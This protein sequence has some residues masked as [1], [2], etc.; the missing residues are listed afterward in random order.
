MEK[1][2]RNLEETLMNRNK[3]VST[4]YACHATRGGT[5]TDADL[6]YTVEKKELQVALKELKKGKAT[7]TDKIPAEIIKVLNGPAFKS[8]QNILSKILQGGEVPIEWLHIRIR[9][10]YK[11]KGKN[12][13]DLGNYRPIAITSTVYKLMAIIMKK[14]LVDWLETHEKLGELQNGFRPGRRGTDNIFILSQLIESR[15]LEGKNMLACFLD[16][17]KA[18][19]SVNRNILWNKMSALGIPLGL[20]G[21]LQNMYNSEQGGYI[22]ELGRLKTGTVPSNIGLKQGCPLSPI[23]FIIY[24]KE[25]EDNLIENNVGIELKY[26]GS[27]A[28]LGRDMQLILT[29]LPESTK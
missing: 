5:G 27:V 2:A 26:E 18:Y 8:L 1:F 11:G 15:R 3:T 12:K 4:E 25:L 16:I 22:Y 23:L 14:R 10:L 6:S 24:L 9:L 20:T 17:S 13:R 19:D 21:V 7:G 28:A 29:K